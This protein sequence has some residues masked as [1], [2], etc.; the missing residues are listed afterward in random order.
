MSGKCSEESNQSLLAPSTKNKSVLPTKYVRG[1]QSK[2][3]CQSFNFQNL[4]LWTFIAQKIHGLPM[5]LKPFQIWSKQPFKWMTCPLKQLLFFFNSCCCQARKN[6]YR[7]SFGACFQFT[8]G[9]LGRHVKSKV[10]VIYD[11][12]KWEKALVAL[13]SATGRSLQTL[14][15]RFLRRTRCRRMFSGLCVV[16]LGG[17]SA[18]SPALLLVQLLVKRGPCCRH[19]SLW[20]V[21]LVNFAWLLSLFIL[22]KSQDMSNIQV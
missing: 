14:R 15:L 9:C 10:F 18:T 1:F 12:L 17:Q 5:K 8:K 16:G 21:S 11:V 4:D 6:W 20:F 13:K 3:T 2:R 7:P 22:R 19:N